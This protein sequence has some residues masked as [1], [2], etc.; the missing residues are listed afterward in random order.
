MK[1]VETIGAERP[2]RS[3]EAFGTDLYRRN[4]FAVTG[5]A[6]YAQGRAV[7]QHKQRLDARLK[8]AGEW[9]GAP[10]SPIAG[11]YSGAEVRQAFEHFA[12]PR[13]RLIDES[14]WWWDQP[15]APDPVAAGCGC[16]QQLHHDHDAAVRAHATVLE[17]ESGRLPLP[18]QERLALWA[19]AGQGWRKV[20]AHPGFTGH[21]RHRIERLDDPR[22]GPD[23]L[24]EVTATARRL[25][26]SPFEQ[27][28]QEAEFANHRLI[29][30]SRDWLE[31][32]LRAA[33]TAVYEQVTDKFFDTI[34]GQL[35]E[36]KEK[37]DAQQFEQ[38][39]HQLRQEVLPAL[40][41]V[42]AYRPYQPAWRHDEIAHRAAVALNNLAIAVATAHMTGH[43][44]PNDAQQQ[45]ILR[46]V[47]TAIEVAPGDRRSDFVENRDDLTRM[48]QQGRSALLAHLPFDSRIRVRLRGFGWRP[49]TY[50][51][52]ATGVLLALALLTTG[53]LWPVGGQVFA[54]GA[55]VTAGLVAGVPTAGVGLFVAAWVGSYLLTV[56]KFFGWL[57]YI[58]MLYVFVGVPLMPLAGGVGV[59]R[60]VFEA[61]S[62]ALA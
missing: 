3:R 50:T 26:V 31:G 45:R 1:D 53:V 9:R 62:G 17:A 24:D 44:W 32:D 30:T 55:G 14:L 42:S 54:Q 34:N 16:P 49:L 48:F 36:A 51:G 37:S 52:Y 56:L 39:E 61:V 15:G 13:H 35:I 19:Q 4:T 6:T 25:L 22:L 28:A 20:L 7:R 59:G 21:L 38:A 58:F 47:R 60:Q 11:S 57:G 23:R 41:Q 43:G 29:R 46:L 5:L 18:E 2:D 10:D 8:V 33:V 12:D 40:Q 27:F